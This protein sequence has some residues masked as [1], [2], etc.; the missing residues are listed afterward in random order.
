MARIVHQSETELELKTTP[1]R[2]LAWIL[3]IAGPAAL[4]LLADTQTVNCIKDE[5]GAV[6]CTI[7]SSHFGL[8]SSRVTMK[9][10]TGARVQEYR[11]RSHNG[12]GSITYRVALTTSLGEFPTTRAFGSDWAA[13]RDLAQSINEFIADP[14]RRSAQLVRP[15]SRSLLFLLIVPAVGASL[16]VAGYNRIRLDTLQDRVEIIRSTPWRRRSVFSLSEVREF[17]LLVK[18]SSGRSRQ[19]VY[20][21]G[22]VLVDGGEVPLIPMWDSSRDRHSEEVAILEG[23]RAGAHFSSATS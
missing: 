23:F 17:R 5:S 13:C 6:S 4:W 11:S 18:R 21:P 16:L 8:P 9:D 10:V 2:L 19:T 22:A 1:P 7:L 12:T 20:C 14:Q 15:W 3:I